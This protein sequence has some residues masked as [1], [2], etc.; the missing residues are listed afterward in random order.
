[1]PSTGFWNITLDTVT[2]KAISVTRKPAL[3]YSIKILRRSSSK[4]S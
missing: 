3:K 2:R 1:V 4:L